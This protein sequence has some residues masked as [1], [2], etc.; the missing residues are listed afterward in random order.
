MVRVLF[1]LALCM[2]TVSAFV[3][4]ANHAGKF[5]KGA[6]LFRVH[7]ALLSEVTLPARVKHVLLEGASVC[8]RGHTVLIRNSFNLF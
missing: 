2:A 3:A 1:A 6:P 7:A 8:T 5:G 4:P